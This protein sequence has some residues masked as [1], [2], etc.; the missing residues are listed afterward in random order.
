MGET[1]KLILAATNASIE[2]LVGLAACMEGE[3]WTDAGGFAQFCPEG[4]NKS[5][6]QIHAGAQATRRDVIIATGCITP[7]IVKFEV[8]KT[9]TS[10]HSR[11]SG[12]GHPVSSDGQEDDEREEARIC[13]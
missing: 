3:S 13:R 10:P 11:S 7:D 9:R 2:D 1:L 4:I 6:C 8:C 12:C 5:A